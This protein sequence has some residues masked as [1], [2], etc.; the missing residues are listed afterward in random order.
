MKIKIERK[1]KPDK[2]K[3]QKQ[4]PTIRVGTHKK[5]HDCLMGITDRKCELWNL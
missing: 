2:P 5:T 1:E 3:K 4:I